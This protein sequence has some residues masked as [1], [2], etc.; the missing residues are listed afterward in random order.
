MCEWFARL[1][2]KQTVVKTH[3]KTS[4]IQRIPLFH[5]MQINTS[6]EKDQTVK[7]THKDPR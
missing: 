3:D 1:S 6:R 4:K 7:M 5:V 2:G